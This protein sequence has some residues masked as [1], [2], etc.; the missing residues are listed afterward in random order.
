[1]TENM[2]SPL[3]GSSPQCEGSYLVGGRDSSSLDLY[4]LL[5]CSRS[6]PYHDQEEDL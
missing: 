1:M 4:F 3:P 5:L 6:I 2:L